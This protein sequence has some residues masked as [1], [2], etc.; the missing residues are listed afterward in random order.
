MKYKLF[1]W[2]VGLSLLVVILFAS[3]S[4]PTV[5]QSDPAEQQSKVTYNAPFT[6]HFSHIMQRRSVEDAFMI[7]PKTEGRFR[8]KDFWT[9]EFIPDEPLTIGDKYRIVIQSDAKSIW[10]KGIGYDAVID[11][12][13]TGPPFVLFTDPQA[14]EVIKKGEAITVMFDRPMDFDSKN[15]SD[16]IRSNPPLSG[17]IEYFGLSAFQFFPEKLKAAQTYEITIPADLE[18]IDGGETAEDYSWI[19]TTS[20]LAIEKSDPVGGAQEIDLD[21][22]IKVYFDAEVSLE[23]IKPGLNA[24]LYPSNDLDADVTRKMDGFFNTEVTYEADQSGEPMKD[25]LVFTPTF[26]YQPGENYR[27]VLK[28]DKDLHLEEDYEL[29]FSTLGTA[30]ETEEA[31]EEKEEETAKEAPEVKTKSV[32]QEDH[33]MQYFIRGENPRLQLDEPL[34]EPV[35]L[36]VC[37]VSSNEYIRVTAASGWNNYR[38]QDTDPVV[39]N[40]SQKEDELIINLDDYFNLNWVTGIYY[41]SI[42][43]GDDRI[44]RHFLIEDTTL[45]MKRSEADL[46]IWALDVKSG[47][48]IPEMGIEVIS[49]DGELIDQGE[50]D[51]MG[52]FS[53][54]EPLDEGIYVRA[55]LEDNEGINRFGLVADRWIL[56]SANEST[57]D[58]NSGIYLLLNQR[59]FSA[60]DSIQIK[61]IWR[62]LE[63]GVLTLPT[64]TQVTVTIEDPRHN[65]IVSKRIPMRRNGSFDGVIAIPG[66]L[67]PGPYFVSVVDLNYQRLS[68]PVPIQIKDSAADLK[69]EWV[70]AESDYAYGIAPVFTAKARYK[71]GI[72]AGNVKGKYLLYRRP[73][74]LQY[75]EGAINY[76]FDTLETACTVNCQDQTLVLTKDFE[77]DPEG[78]IKLILSDQKDKFPAPGYDYDLQIEASLPG[79]E[80]VR[81]HQSFKVHQGYYDLGLGTKHALLDMDEPIEVSV[82]ALSHEGKML[83]GKKVKLTLISSKEQ[84]KV[85]EENIDTDSRPVTTSIAVAPTMED[86]VYVLQ[87]KSL[88]EKRNEVSAEQLIYISIN[89]LQKIDDE[90]LLAL[91]QTKYFIGGRA[92]LLINES[93]AS[94]DNPVPVLLTYERNGLLGYKMLE[95]TQPI[96]RFAVPIKEN[97]MPHFEMKLTRFNRG[98]TPSFS[99]VSRTVDVG[100]DASQIFINLSFE[101]AQPQPGDEVIF[102]LKTYDFQ[103]RPLDSV[104]TLHLFNQATDIPEFSY[105]SFFPKEILPSRTAT[106]I[107]PGH[108][109]S[110]V[111][112]YEEAMSPFFP[113]SFE[114]VY[115]EPLI[116]TN[117]AGEAAI[118]VKMPE[119]RTDLF[120]HAIATKNA[121]QFGEA[122]AVLRVNKELV[123][124]P[125]LPS[126][127]VP[128]D[129]TILAATVKNISDHEVQSRLEFYSPD[130]APKGDL[131]RHLTLQPGQQTEMAFNVFIDT[132]LEKNEVR[133]GFRSGNDQAEET[134]PLKHYMTSQKIA[135]TGLL[136]DIWTG[137][138]KLP[139]D[140]YR[141]LGMLEMA[142]GASPLVFVRGFINGLD[143]YEYDFTYLLALKLLLE[144][145]FDSSQ[146]LVSQ[147]LARADENGGYRFWNETSVN[148]TLSALVLLAYSEATEQGVHIDSIQFNRLIDFLWKALD[149]TSL[150]MDDQAF[151]L[152]TLGEAG[153]LDTERS[154]RYFQDRETMKLKG[155]AFLLLNLD[156]LVQAGQSSMASARDVLKAELIDEAIEEVD[157]VYF[158]APDKTTAILLYAMSR[159]GADSKLL[160]GMV[161]YLAAQDPNHLNQL[162]PEEMLWTT[163]AFRSYLAQAAVSGINYIAQVKINGGLILDQSVTGNSVDQVFEKSVPASQLNTEGIND[164][165]IKKKGS[166]PLY[167][168]ARLFSYLDPSQATRVEEGMIV[169]R[170]LY[171]ITEDGK[172][173]PVTA[174][175]KGHHYLSELE[176]IIPKDYSLVALTD[177]IPAGMKVLSGSVGKSEWFTQY[178]LKNSQIT[179]FAPHVPAGVYKVST[180]LRAVL[181][182]TYLHLPATVQVIFEPLVLGRTEGNTMQIID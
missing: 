69:L 56:D 95:L 89:P 88:D 118:T 109:I 58:E 100:N 71:N 181:G 19:V 37:P 39:I 105:A 90:L 64:A 107:S 163:L 43:I 66:D 171:E 122:S 78:K 152:W 91:D 30:E 65:F 126:V 85:F 113:D 146:N 138:V 16:L 117:S 104:V 149:Q 166:G 46:L 174:F 76:I 157:M 50:T 125:V 68:A 34:S 143:Y 12:L 27:F 159:L 79:S 98:V 47:R 167:F 17:H 21:R 73:S 164:I 175:K 86:G 102:R 176:V 130:L 44:I 11:Y 103:N 106:N 48:P 121:G 31:P 165:F 51:E 135:D 60:G 116:T 40:P 42:K 131:T 178:D 29:Q 151:V 147:L 108:L 123:I 75:E 173:I 182:G 22:S 36:S 84:K 3:F 168:D 150:N 172:K 4:S 52:L 156:Q 93:T 145:D 134:I 127:L 112:D 72:P 101:P 154:L 18:A 115:F 57:A 110:T 97:M 83:P 41:A 80:P 160:D 25:T 132:T 54:H 32:I 61:G 70:E 99:S 28:S 1:P 129:Q 141:G 119:K 49:Y 6:V 139:K 137:R 170:K 26:D 169:V 142:M 87:A 124:E 10:L 140:A 15:E 2:F 179:Y 158:D 155:R 82:L 8:W 153:Q 67:T 23:A 35:L 7:L 96:T 14:G 63:E 180:E 136:S 45:L 5:I 128:G 33:L 114:S 20:D 144:E 38:C 92:H 24:L 81:L 74:K 77:F 53:L 9:L 148:S 133:V 62:N 94:E 177:T 13:V 55:K 111:P 162:D 59:I 161:S 120:I